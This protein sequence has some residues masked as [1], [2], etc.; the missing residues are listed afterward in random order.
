MASLT[1]VPPKPE[2]IKY[3]LELNETEAWE[4]YKAT[5]EKSGL[6]KLYREFKALGFSQDSPLY[7]RP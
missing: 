2:P 3:L 4:L 1:L 5:N 6:A 7:P